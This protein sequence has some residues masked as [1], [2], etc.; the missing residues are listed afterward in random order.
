MI[1]AILIT[2][3]S[4]LLLGIPTYYSLAIPHKP[5]FKVGFICTHIDSFPAASGTGLTEHQAWENMIKNSCDLM[6]NSYE[7]QRGPIDSDSLDFVI[8]MEDCLNRKCTS[9]KEL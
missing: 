8:I 5:E 1:R 6:I 9:V 3:F 7:N 2:L 4:S